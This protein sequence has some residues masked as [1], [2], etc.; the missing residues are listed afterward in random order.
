MIVALPVLQGRI[1]PVLDT[2][3]RLL[4][5]TC[6]RGKEVERREIILSPLPAQ[7]LADRVAQLR[8]DVL[9]CAALSEALHRALEPRGIRVRQHLCGPVEA[10]LSAFRCGQ[11]DREEFRM[12]GCWGHH[13][14]GELRSG[15]LVAR[16][17]SSFPCSLH[18]SK[19]AATAVANVIGSA[20]P[21]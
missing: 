8:V 13:L 7:A 21:E 20:S 5:V 6:R 1:S 4:V 11:L 17:T 12:P 14:G 19:T 3:M 16:A 10:V 18:R 2:A 9:L 15:C